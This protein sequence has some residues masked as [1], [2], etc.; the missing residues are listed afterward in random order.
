MQDGFTTMPAWRI[1]P[2]G[3]RRVMT[4]VPISLERQHSI[5]ATETK[6]VG[7]HSV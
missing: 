6:T 1:R 4:S 5:S 7:D 2:A 3:G